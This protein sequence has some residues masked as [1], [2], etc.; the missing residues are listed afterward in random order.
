MHEGFLLITAYFFV[1]SVFFVVRHIAAYKTYRLI[2]VLRISTLKL[3]NSP[4]FTSASFIY[5]SNWAL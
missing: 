1:A 2:P 5:V 3:I 4:T